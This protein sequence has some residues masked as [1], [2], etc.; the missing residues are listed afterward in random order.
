ML[1]GA[2]R[3]R[4]S[5][6]QTEATS[7]LDGCGTAL[8]TST[9]VSRS[10]NMFS[11]TAH[12]SEQDVGVWQPH[13]HQ[14]VEGSPETHI[15][16]AAISILFR[17]GKD[18]QNLLGCI[19]EAAPHPNLLTYVV[20]LPH[21]NSARLRISQVLNHIRYPLDHIWVYNPCSFAGTRRYRIFQLYRDLSK[22][23]V[24]CIRGSSS[25]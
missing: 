25:I 13:Q 5:G 10:V 8:W 4:Y 24:F 22:F 14:R 18:L 16:P 2:S 15:A 3:R 11:F 1:G 7:W 17:F 12:Q 9:E 19:G 21:K 20:L 23:H 6:A